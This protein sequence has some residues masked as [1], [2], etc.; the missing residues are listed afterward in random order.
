MRYRR[1]GGELVET[2]L[3]RVSVDELM[4]AGPVREFRWYKGRTFYSGWY[5]SATT[6]GMVAYESRLELARILLADFDSSVCGVVAQPFL[7]QGLPTDVG[8][9]RH[10]P[11][12]LLGHL[13]GR[14]TVVDV[15]PAHRLADPLVQQVF[16]WTGELVGLR[17]WG[18][19]T[20]SGADAVLL[21]NVRFLSGYRRPWLVDLAL[22]EPILESVGP[23]S[24]LGGIEHA[25]AEVARTE[26][27]R[28]VLLHL[29][30]SGVLATDLSRPLGA[31]SPIW[32]T[33]NR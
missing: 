1:T 21:G 7:L 24:T 6:G 17:G 19:E 8:L 4:A 20:W 3:G 13:D 9:R 10:V 28:P 23:Q 16:A 15:K 32:R 31:G 30:W 27:V 5:W 11:D 22:R 2:T 12:L 18:F 29:L 26:R 25:T 14:V 33:E